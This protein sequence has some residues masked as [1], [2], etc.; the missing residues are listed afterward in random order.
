MKAFELNIINGYQ[1]GSFGPADGVTTAQFTKMI[2]RTF[3]LETNIEYDY[4][5]VNEA[6]WYNEFAGT[7]QKY[8]LFPDREDELLPNKKLTRYEV[9]TAIYQVLTHIEN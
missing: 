8:N 4:T 7:A 1:D 6:D 2:V 5:D 9:A 3:E